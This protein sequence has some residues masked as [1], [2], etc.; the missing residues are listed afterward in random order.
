MRWTGSGRSADVEDRRGGGGGFPIGKVGIGGTLILGVLSLIFGRN[1]LSGGDGGK[2]VNDPAEEKQVEFMSF[3]LDDAQAMWAKELPKQANT[4]YRKAKLV[5]FRDSVS[6]QC[7]MADS[8]VGPFYCPG[9]EKVYLDFQFFQ[10]LKDRLGA[11][12]DFAQA[13]VIAHEIGHHVQTILG[14]DKNMRS[15]QRGK[16]KTE[17]NELSVRM[18]LQADCYAGVWAHSTEQR[19]ILENGDLEEAIEAARSIGDDRLQKEGSGHVQPE[20]WTH[21]SSA[22][23]MRWFKRGKD[24]GLISDCDTFNAGQLSKL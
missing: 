2:A 19:N 1:L 5:L 12:G 22:M 4:D 10:V 3:V 8:A 17:Q 11:P 20:K 16:S 24:S 15:L 21:G 23:R 6:S 18:E 13:Y 14:A 7:G 9:D